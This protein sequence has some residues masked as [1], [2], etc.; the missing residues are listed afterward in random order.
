M[1]S[2]GLGKKAVNTMPPPPP[3]LVPH[4]PVN[5]PGQHTDGQSSDSDVDIDV[6]IDDMSSSQNETAAWIE[7]Q[8]QCPEPF[9]TAPELLLTRAARLHAPGGLSARRGFTSHA[10]AFKAVKPTAAQAQAVRS[11]FV[12]QSSV[13]ATSPA[14]PESAPLP[15]S[16]RHADAQHILLTPSAKQHATCSTANLADLGPGLKGCRYGHKPPLYPAKRTHGEDTDLRQQSELKQQAESR[17]SSSA[18][19]QSVSG[20]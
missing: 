8:R 13:L 1:Q 7:K 16:T 6:N 15:A 17:M 20:Q 9:L 10:Q 4:R 12:A 3:R 18:G 14:A 19:V 11:V 5:G 2:A